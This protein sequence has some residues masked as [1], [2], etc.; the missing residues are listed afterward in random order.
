MV[1]IV[2]AKNGVLVHLVH[3]VHPVHFVHPIKTLK[4]R[5]TS[6]W[7]TMQ[8]IQ[9]KYWQEFAKDGDG[10]LCTALKAAAKRREVFTPE[11]LYNLAAMAIEKHFMA[12][13]MFHGDL[14]D[15][16]TMADLIHSVERHLTLEQNL[17]ERLI[18]LDAFQE[19]CDQDNIRRRPPNETELKAILATAREVRDFV[20][21]RLG[22][23]ATA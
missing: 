19:I 11:I 17:K 1:D 10:Y 2:D 9:L 18:F 15:N 12:L 7:P 5:I 8:P 21:E 14:A 6:R 13:L 23:A 4:Q 3:L 20:G 22:L 16:H